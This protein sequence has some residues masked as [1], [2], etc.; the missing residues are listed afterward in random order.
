MD[1]VQ[2]LLVA[3][4]II[5]TIM[6]VVIGYQVFYILRQLRQTIDKANKVLDNTQSISEDVKAPVSSISELLMGL[7]S[8]MAITS[9]L[10]HLRERKK[11]ERTP[12]LPQ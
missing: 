2:A 11:H 1:T 6:L 12:S 8:G 9:F 3:V 10:K 7:K 5:L 4:V